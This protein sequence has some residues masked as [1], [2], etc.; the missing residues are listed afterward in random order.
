MIAH[1]L[2]SVRAIEPDRVVVVTGV[3]S[4][5]L[6]PVLREMDPTLRIVHQKEQRGTGD[7]VARYCRELADFGGDVIVLYGDT[8][9]IRPRR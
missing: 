9:F 8:P 2:A 6:D 1:A 3:G 4:D 5:Q 7:A